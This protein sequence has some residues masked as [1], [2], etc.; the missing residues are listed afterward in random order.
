LWILIVAALTVFDAAVAAPESAA[1]SDNGA[2][3][4]EVTVTGRLALER[5]VTTFI[6]QIMALENG[7][8]LP[9]WNDP[10]CPGVD[11]LPREEGEFVLERISEIARAAGVP[12]AGERC[13]A[14]LV[15][16]MTAGTQKLLRGLDNHDR[17]ALFGPTSPTVIDEFVAKP[18]VVKV[19][20]NSGE[21][22][23]YGTKLGQPLPG[24]FSALDNPSMNYA[25][26]SHIISN[27]V[28]RMTSVFVF[29]DQTRLSGVSR[30]QFADYVA[31]VGLA[32]LK[33]GAQLGDA[34]TILKLFDGGPSAAPGGMSDWDRAFLRSLY[35]T[36]QR[37]KA[38][39]SKIAHAM[40]D[41]IASH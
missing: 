5:K 37:L 19:W 34:P 36:N 33:P 11:G 2:P 13:Q 41:E 4:P 9:R 29:V 16:V 20:Y 1:G 21:W 30:G 12:L 18:G 22:T 25:D 28:W 23:A 32:E 17:Q 27:A 6:N 26:S 35:S 10:V 40:V 39:R 14:N 38:Q 31:M 24:G 7:E 15:I 3:L 8:G